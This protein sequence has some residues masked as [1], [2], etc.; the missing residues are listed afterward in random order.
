MPADGGALQPIR[1]LRRDQDDQL[2]G[3]DQRQPAKLP[4]SDLG[5]EKLP[6]P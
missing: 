3:V 5:L 4:C 1:P 2:E 6:M